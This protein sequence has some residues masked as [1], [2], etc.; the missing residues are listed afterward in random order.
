MVST[1]QRGRASSKRSSRFLAL[2]M[3]AQKFRTKVGHSQKTNLPSFLLY[4][5]I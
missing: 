2:R 5:E 4:R 3:N 1:S